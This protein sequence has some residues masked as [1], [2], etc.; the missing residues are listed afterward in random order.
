MLAQVLQARQLLC[1]RLA[2]LGRSLPLAEDRFI[3]RVA[4]QDFFLICYSQF[5]IIYL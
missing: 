2:V 1:S 4:L 3:P 5:C